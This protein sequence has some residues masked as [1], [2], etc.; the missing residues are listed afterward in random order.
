MALRGIIF[1]H[2]GTLVDSEGVHFSLWRDVLNPLGISFSLEEYLEHHCGV[3]TLT[4]AQV[5]VDQYQLPLSAETLYQQKQAALAGWLKIQPFPL[6]QGAREAMV[7]CK[8][9]GLRIGIATGASDTELNSSMIAHHLQPLVDAST[10]RDQVSHSKPAADTYTRT[11]KQ[12]QLNAD[13]VIAVEDSATGL[14]SAKAAGLRCIVVA[15]AFAAGQD[16]SAADY[17]VANLS[18]AA[19]LALTL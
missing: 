11:L 5:I 15:Y 18:D 3:P 8:S 14:A 1:D 4:N 6:M 16:L 10:T 7:R 9:A 13:D 12:L 19:S 17:T 2:D